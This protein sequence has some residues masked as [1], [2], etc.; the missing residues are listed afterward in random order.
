MIEREFDAEL[1]YN[2]IV[3]F[4]VDKHGYP[5]EA[6]NRIAQKVVR[7]EAVRRTCKNIGCRHSMDDHI[8]NAET[9]LV[10]ECACRRF[11]RGAAAAA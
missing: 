8:R 11:E 1:L 5:R 2:R 7:R 9:C 4:Y 10:L 3:H 6:A